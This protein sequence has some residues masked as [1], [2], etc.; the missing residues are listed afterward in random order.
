MRI[1][2]LIT[3]PSWSSL[4]VGGALSPLSALPT[5]YP[6]PPSANAAL[7]APGPAA[8]V[9]PPPKPSHT[10]AK[11]SDSR[12]VLKRK[13][14]V[15]VQERVNDFWKEK[16]GRYVMQGDYLSLI[17]E[18]GNCISWKSYLWDVP[19]GVLK[20]ALNAGVNTLPTSDNLKR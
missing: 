11:R 4:E 13:I 20:F 3:L 2:S 15:G 5:A 12:E 9:S 6:V 14:Q 18:E 17:V 16:I 8:P 7:P 1:E 10:P 19:Q